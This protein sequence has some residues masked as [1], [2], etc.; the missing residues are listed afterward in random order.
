MTGMIKPDD[1]T[2]GCVVGRFMRHCT[3]CYDG[4]KQAQIRAETEDEA[5]TMARTKKV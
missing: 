5:R 1:D 2:G 3:L 4:R